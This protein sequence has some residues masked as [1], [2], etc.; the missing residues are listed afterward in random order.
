VAAARNPASDGTAY[1][2]AVCSARWLGLGEVHDGGDA[3]VGQ[4][5][6]A[7]PGAGVLVVMGV[8]AFAGQRGQ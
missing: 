2:R 4:R 1:A 5:I 3:F 6:Q 7:G 8:L